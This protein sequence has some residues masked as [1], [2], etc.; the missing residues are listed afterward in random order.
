MQPPYK[1]TSQGSIPW[2]RTARHF[3]RGVGRYGDLGSLIRSPLRVRLTATPP[4]GLT[5]GRVHVAE[6]EYAPVSETGPE[7]VWGFDSLRGHFEP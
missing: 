5:R 1:R 2:S 3:N 6:L 7:R 4:R